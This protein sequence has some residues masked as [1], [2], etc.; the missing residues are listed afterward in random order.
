MLTLMGQKTSNYTIAIAIN[1]ILLFVIVVPAAA[2]Q[3]KGY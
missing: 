1:L 3:H 2:Q